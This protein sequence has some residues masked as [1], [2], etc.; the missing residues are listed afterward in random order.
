MAK[1]KSIKEIKLDVENL[2][3]LLEQAEQKIDNQR[4]DL[5]IKVFSPILENDEICSFFDI[6]QKNKKIMDYI[7]EKIEKEI[8]SIIE[9]IETGKIKFNEV[10]PETVIEEKK[11]EKFDTEAEIIEEEKEE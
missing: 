8:F 9:E 1:K 11:L 5:A 4:D 2:R 10:A 7:K 3:K 6:N